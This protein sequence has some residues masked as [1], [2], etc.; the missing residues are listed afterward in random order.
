MLKNTKY[1]LTFAL[2]WAIGSTYWYTCNIKYLCDAKTD[3]SAPVVT[4]DNTW[5]ELKSQP[6]TVYFGPNTDNI[7]TEGVDQKLK[8]IVAYLQKNKSAKINITGHTNYHKNISFTEKLGLD[9]SN[10]LKSLLMS[11]GADSSSITTTSKGQRE[12]IARYGDKNAESLNRRAV[13]NI[14]NE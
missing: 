14:T 8:D 10:K 1:L 13:I 2:V 12:T 11:Y 7:L 3:T 4:I 6:L 9:R 5:N